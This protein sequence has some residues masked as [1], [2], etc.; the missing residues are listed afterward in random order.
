MSD[1]RYLLAQ[2]RANPLCYPS[3]AYCEN[4]RKIM[5]E[6]SQTPCVRKDI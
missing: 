5:G 4:G 2:N 6:A 3:P 1:W